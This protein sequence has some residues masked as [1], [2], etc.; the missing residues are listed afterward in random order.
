[1]NLDKKFLGTG[2]GYPPEFDRI[3]K[4]V[5]MVSEEEDIR[6]SLT[7]LLGT[8]PGERIMRPTYGCGIKSLVFENMNESVL[9]QIEEMIEQAVLFFEP[10]I[11]LDR[12]EVNTDDIY[13]GVVKIHLVYTIRMTN[14]RSNMVYPFYFREGTNIR[15]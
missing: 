14:N 8:S 13:N 12:I 5:R 4:T 1:M 15:L 2:W 3:T 9:T 11:T 10:R 6:E 7:I